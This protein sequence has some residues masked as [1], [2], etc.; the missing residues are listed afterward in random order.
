[1]FSSDS[2][3]SHNPASV[4]DSPQASAEVPSTE[5]NLPKPPR[6]VRY[7]G[8][9]PKGFQ[10]KYKE[11]QPEKYSESIKK[12]LAKGQTP[13]G[14]HVPIL[15]QEILEILNPKPGQV[16]LDCT[17]GYGG[18]AE[19][20]AEKLG[21]SGRL[22]G[23]DLDSEEMQRTQQRLLDKGLPVT[24]HHSNF[25]GLIKIIQSEGH[26]QVDHIL[27]DLGVSSMQLDR[28]ERGFSFKNDGPLDMRL[29][30]SRGQ[31]AAQWLKTVKA[32]VLE[33]ILEIHGNEP[34][35][36]KV[37][38][39]IIE[40]VQAERA[41]E[42]TRD[43]MHLVFQAKGID[44]KKF[45]RNS[46]FQKHP[47]TRT[48]QAIRMTI[49]REKANLEHLL[50]MLPMAL[51]AGGRAAILSFHSGEREL[52][53]RSFSE[54]LSKGWYIKGNQ[55]PIVP[56]QLEIYDNPRARSA[57]LHWVERSAIEG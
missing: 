37:T 44:V 56:S 49:N 42:T 5:V 57:Q 40:A 36:A 23:L 50:R 15:W 27:A 39:T 17:L 45:K 3:Q 31:S 7:K 2:P 30:R 18:H 55:G 33:E 52:V 29:D 26:E 35:A 4:S 38:R 6:R 25:A 13:A 53:Q 14:M 9:H 21:P 1:M 20:I 48:F 8:T 28:P 32:E 24:A 54:G 19:K 47:A 22:I 10:E 16:V 41:P 11:H 51:K 34:D 43:L 12:V 46:A